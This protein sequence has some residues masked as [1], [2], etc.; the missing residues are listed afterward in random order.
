MPKFR[1]KNISD[2]TQI[3]PNV[4]EVKAGKTIFTEE[5]INNSNFE[6]SE[7]EDTVLETVIVEEE[8]EEEPKKKGKK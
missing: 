6:E 2:S 7:A 1:Y 8:V 3:I 5:P 4:G